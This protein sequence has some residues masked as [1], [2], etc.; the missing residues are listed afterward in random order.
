MHGS[1]VTSQPCALIHFWLLLLGLLL[2]LLLLHPFNGLFSR[3]SWI[4]WYQKAITSLGLNEARDY[5]LGFWMQWHQ[6][7]RMRTI[8]T[9]LQT[10]NHT[11]TS[12][13]NFL[14]AGCSSWRPTSILRTVSKHWRPVLTSALYKSLTYLLTVDRPCSSSLPTPIAFCLVL[15][16][17]L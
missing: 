1:H 11:N 3:T 2:L 10:D 13:L 9:S 4:S 17:S 8:C 12:S 16:P 14:Q 7:D 15:Q 6:L 5:G